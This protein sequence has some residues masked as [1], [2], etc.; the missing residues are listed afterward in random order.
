LRAF[1]ARRVRR[2]VPALAVTAAVTLLVGALVLSPLELPGLARDGL[3]AVTYTSN[4]VF[5]G[6]ATDYFA[7]KVEESLFLHTWSL[8]VEEQFYLVWPLAALAVAVAARRRPRL[9]RPLAAGVF[10]VTAAASLLLAVHLTATGTPWSF[11][12]LPTRAWEFGVAAVLAAVGRRVAPGGVVG[13]VGPVAGLL[14]I[15]WAASLY[16]EATPY[17]GVPTLLP[18]LGTLAVVHWCRDGWGP[19]R[20]LA[21]APLR[22]IGRVSYSWYLWHWPAILLAVAVARSDTVAVRLVGAVVALGLAAATHAL[23]EDPLR[24]SAALQA[25]PWRTFAVGALATTLVATTAFGVRR[26]GEAQ[27]DDPLVWRLHVAR[28]QILADPPRCHRDA[29]PAGDAYCTYGRA[30]G[31]ETVALVGD[32]HAMQWL[33]GLA[34]AADRIGVRLVDS[35]EGGC[36]PIGL[37]IALS[38]TRLVPSQGCVRHRAATE[39]VLAAEHP[40]LVVVAMTDFVGRVLRPDGSLPPAEE[41]QR[42]VRRATADL[43]ARLRAGGAA[44]VFI[45]DNPRPTT[46]PVTCVGRTRSVATCTPT[47]AEAIEPVGWLDDLERDVSAEFGLAAPFDTPSLL[48]DDATCRI[49]DGDAFVYADEHHLSGAYTAARVPELAVWLRLAVGGDLR[50]APPVNRTV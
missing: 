18:V 38:A 39:R 1:W 33:P 22:R 27:L 15:G 11:F 17:P 45:L 5:A 14:A 2:L 31:A 24:F 16:T 26:Y 29:T 21:T 19:G 42:M 20:L 10:G 37:P 40:D 43:V 7:P 30:D 48:C 3:A 25:A 8:A 28:D 41:Q 12:G 4:L 35:S 47:A 23:V 44:V 32:S 9:L 34:G 49:D 36:P 13:L 46:N 6:D 50:A